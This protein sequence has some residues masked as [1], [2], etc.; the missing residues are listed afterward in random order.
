MN[1]IEVQKILMEIEVIYPNFKNGVTNPTAL[2]DIWHK[3]LQ[4]YEYADVSTALGEYIESSNSSFAPSVSQLI[5]L[6]KKKRQF[7]LN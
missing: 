3:F 2:I 7:L 4:K 5:G 1:R 6:V